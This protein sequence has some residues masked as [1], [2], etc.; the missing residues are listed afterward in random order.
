M[1][2]SWHRLYEIIMES[3]KRSQNNHIRIIAALVILLMIF[4]DF[5]SVP[6]YAQDEPE[7]DVISC[8]VVNDTRDM[9]LFEKDADK[10]VYPASTT[11][12]L[13]AL[14]VASSIESGSYSLDDTFAAYDGLY[15]DIPWDGSTENIQAGEVM[16][17]R[18]YLHC[19]LLS[20]ANEAC[21]ALAAFDSGST[22]EFVSKMNA[23][24][25][26]LG[27]ENSHFADTHGIYR[28]DHYTT[29]RDMYKIF[30]AVMDDPIAGS[31]CS[32]LEYT[33]PETNKS[34][35]RE[36]TNTNLLLHSDMPMYYEYAIG[37]KTGFTEEAGTCLVSAAE[38]DG[39][40][41]I[42]IIMGADFTESEDGIYYP[43]SFGEARGLYE[44]CY[45][46]Y[47]DQPVISS[48]DVINSLTVK[49]G[50]DAETVDIVPAD[51][52]FR[53]MK[54]SDAENYITYEVE[55]DKNELRAPVK[56]GEK[57]GEITAVYNGEII[58]TSKLTA[59]SDIEL[60]LSKL[61]S[62]SILV[63]MVIVLVLLVLAVIVRKKIK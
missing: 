23:K 45:S 16:T 14:V 52:V 57:V 25:K 19:A 56:A 1:E 11:K 30:R 42:C 13:M 8:I 41:L 2:R 46:E 36:L 35:E 7:P 26:E 3:N 55:L 44:W 48:E 17:V 49:N 62:G 31:I 29:A 4:A 53:Y 18:D 5:A 37:G 6:A 47:G 27:C 15:Y 10:Q 50:K 34:D 58:G 20:S 54:R 9:V 61:I 28:D 38:K 24:A 33:V 32:T 21:N 22:D 12:V 63:R 43:A 40:R 39:D 60:S 51:D 59:A